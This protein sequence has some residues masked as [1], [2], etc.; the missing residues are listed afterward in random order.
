MLLRWRLLVP[1]SPDNCR[2][3]YQNRSGYL[4]FAKRDV[5]SEFS[6]L[7]DLVW[8][9]LKALWPQIDGNCSQQYLSVSG[10]YSKAYQNKLHLKIWPTQLRVLTTSISYV[11]TCSPTSVQCHD[12]TTAAQVI[13]IVF[14]GCHNTAAVH[15]FKYVCSPRL[16]WLHCF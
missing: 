9:V 4:N 14:I 3:G 12:Q 2:D 11:G 8:S 1:F 13:R 16:A 5:S 15:M 10:T 7:L 6:H